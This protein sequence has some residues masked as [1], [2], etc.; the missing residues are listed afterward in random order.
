MFLEKIYIYIYIHSPAICRTGRQYQIHGCILSKISD[1]IVEGHRDTANRVTPSN[2]A[3][4]TCCVPRDLFASSTTCSQGFLPITNC[5]KWEKI[6]IPSMQL[7]HVGS[8]LQLVKGQNSGIVRT[9]I[10]KYVDTY[11]HIIYI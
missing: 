5:C 3:R 10:I 4:R 2:P 9:H 8:D 11:T 1:S 7:S 6:N